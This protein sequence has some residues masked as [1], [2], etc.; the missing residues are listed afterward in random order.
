MSGHCVL[1]SIC[2]CRSST[3]RHERILRDFANV[4]ALTIRAATNSDGDLSL[5][6]A[7]GGKAASMPK[8]Q[9]Q[10]EK[11]NFD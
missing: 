4:N 10:V 5:G 7:G 1:G 8:V 3:D 9:Q 6:C 2:R 11:Y